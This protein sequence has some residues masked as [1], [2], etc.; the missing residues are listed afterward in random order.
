MRVG[1]A[2]YSQKICTHTHTHAHK[3][4]HT[5]SPLHWAV[6]GEGG[7]VG[8]RGS[9]IEPVVTA[10]TFTSTLGEEREEGGGRQWHCKK[11]MVILNLAK[12][13]SVAA[14]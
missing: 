6:A 13:I 1:S 7:G 12:V 2:C 10:G 8:L 9:H 3:H 5:H 14:E 4:T 11:E